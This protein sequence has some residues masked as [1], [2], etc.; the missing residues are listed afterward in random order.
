MA[1]TKFVVEDSFDAIFADLE[2]CTMDAAEVTRKELG[3]TV[4]EIADATPRYTGE[5]ASAWA[6]AADKMGAPHKPV[7]PGVRKARN[8]RATYWDPVEKKRISGE[9]RVKDRTALGRSQGG[10]EETLTG[11]TGRK[12]ASAIFEAWNAV[13]QL[14]F[15]EYGGLVRDGKGTRRLPGK[16]IVRDAIRRM[17]QRLGPLFSKVVKANIRRPKKYVK[18]VIQ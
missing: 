17:K 18:K 12:L 13:K 10:Y 1:R 15:V 11:A 16:H 9:Y 4:G 7:T 5:T 2:R 3:K 6:A 14:T 8:E